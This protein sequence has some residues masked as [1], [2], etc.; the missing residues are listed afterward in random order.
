[1]SDYEPSYSDQTKTKLIVGVVVVALIGAVLLFTEHTKSQQNNAA[2]MATTSQQTAT[3]TTPSQTTT[4]TGSTPV[5]STA[6]FKDG[7]YTASSDYRVPPGIES[8]KVTLTVKNG[9]V[10]NSSIIN[11]ENDHTSVVFQQSFSHDYQAYVVGKS[12]STLDLSVISG[13][14]DTTQGFNDAVAQIRNQAQA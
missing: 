4:S 5:S 11:S 13:A 10:T 7:T 9:Q 2:D 6:T 3:Q 14:S 1:M 8:I 12:L